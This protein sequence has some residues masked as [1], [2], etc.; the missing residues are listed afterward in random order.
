MT[1]GKTYA[2][3]VHPE[4]GCAFVEEDPLPHVGDGLCENLGPATT[5]SREEAI[6]LGIDPEK[7]VI[8]WRTKIE[9]KDKI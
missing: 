2:W 4:S 9:D 5:G 7:Y 8:H 6:A 3:Y 1:P